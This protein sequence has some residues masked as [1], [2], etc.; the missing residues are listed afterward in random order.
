VETYRINNETIIISCHSANEDT[1]DK[2]RQTERDDDDSLVRYVSRV[3]ER[4][5]GLLT[6]FI[7]DVIV[8]TP[9]CHLANRKVIC[10]S[11][12]IRH[13]TLR[14]ILATAIPVPRSV[15]LAVL[16]IV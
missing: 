7:G 4:R 12:H 5:K 11:A 8:R 13:I 2:R 15:I 10:L 9:E 6:W 16:K 1:Y 14:F 3:G